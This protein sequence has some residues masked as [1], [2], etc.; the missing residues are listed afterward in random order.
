RGR[1]AGSRCGPLRTAGRTGGD[2]SFGTTCAGSPGPPRPILAPPIRAS[3]EGDT[4]RKGGPVR[5]PAPAPRRRPERAGLLVIR[6]PHSATPL[7]ARRAAQAP[8][9]R[10]RWVW[11]AGEGNR[12]SGDR[13]GRRVGP[14]T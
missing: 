11:R 4:A 7:R 1:D 3:G 9:G 13:A 12:G 6:P 2:R 14:G 10:A 5:P 8:R